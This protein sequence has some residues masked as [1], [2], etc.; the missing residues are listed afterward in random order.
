MNE[1]IEMPRRE[2]AGLVAAEV[3]RYSLAEIRER[4]NLVQEVMRGIMKLNTHYGTIPGTP[5]PTLYKPGAEVLCVTFRIAPVYRILDLSTDLVAR[6]R[7]TCIGQHQVSDIMLGE[8]VG[9]CSSA[10]EK[11]KWRAAVCAEEFS[12]VPETMRRLKFYKNGGKATQVRTEAADLSNTVLKMACK[13][14][15]IAMTLNVT[16]ASDIFTQDIEDLPEELRH[17]EAGEQAPIQQA[18]SQEPPAELL[19]AAQTAASKGLVTYQEFFAGAGAP[20]RKLLAAHHDGLKAAAE[21]VDRARTVE[22][23][24]AAVAAKPLSAEMQQ[25]LADF[26]A[27]ADEGLEIFNDAWGRLSPDT[28]DIF[29]TQFPALKA[30]AEAVGVAK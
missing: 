19:A 23:Y 14:A 18:A 5:K 10:E 1:V 22:A 28:Q 4:V 16:A 21:A 11:Y 7:V 20:N 9:E 17:Q 30:R 29:V 2:S 27:I 12:L 24:P 25:M 8:G 15:M 26:E 6:F 3:H 13:R